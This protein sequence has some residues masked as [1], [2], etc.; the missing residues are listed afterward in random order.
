MFCS[1]VRVS[2][3]AC[4]P[5]TARS[6]MKAAQFGLLSFRSLAV[7]VGRI[8]LPSF[9]WQPN[10][11]PLNH[12]RFALNYIIYGPL[13]SSGHRY[14]LVITQVAL[15]RQDHDYIS[16]SLHDQYTFWILL[17]KILKRSSSPGRKH[18]MSAREHKSHLVRFVLPPGLEPGTTDPKS[19][20]IS[21]SPQE[22]T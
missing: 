19:V 12:T 14:Q 15:P 18:P 11:L 1:P 8:E 10:V 22:R 5:A 6:E 21:I 3:E 2:I 9:D 17:R 7:R 13:L 16:R 20:M 4:L